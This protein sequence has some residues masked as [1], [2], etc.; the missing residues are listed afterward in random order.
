MPAGVLALLA[1][2][3]IGLT[4]PGSQPAVTSDAPLEKH[5]TASAFDGGIFR[6]AIS[7]SDDSVA[8]VDDKDPGSPS[9][10]PRFRTFRVSNTLLL[11]DGQ[12]SQ[13]T[14]ATDP[15][16]GEVMRIDVT[17]NVLK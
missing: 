7:V 2:L 17:L 8:Y 9:G 14:T 3:A 15:I 16:T 13:M 4:K 12:T 11:R 1:M 5:A 6:L 10:V